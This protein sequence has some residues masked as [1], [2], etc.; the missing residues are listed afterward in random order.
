MSAYSQFGS[1]DPVCAKCD[2][3]RTPFLITG[4]VS[5]LA[6]GGMIYG[7]LAV[8]SAGKGRI[9]RAKLIRMNMSFGA[10]QVNAGVTY[11]W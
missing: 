3:P 11:Q 6:A 4:L 1:F 9:R 8:L 5:S 7:G 10:Q 2:D